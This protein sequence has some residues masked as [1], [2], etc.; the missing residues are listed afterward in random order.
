MR[1][2]SFSVLSSLLSPPSQHKLLSLRLRHSD[3]H[4]RDQQDW[5]EAQGTCRRRSRHPDCGSLRH[6][7]AARGSHGNSP[8]FRWQPLHSRLGPWSCVP[9]CVL[10]LDIS[11]QVNESSAPGALSNTRG[12]VA[13]AHWDVP[14]CGDSGERSFWPACP[15]S[16][17]RCHNP[18]SSSSACKQTA[19]W[20]RRT[21]GT[22]CLR[23]S[24]RAM[25]RAG[26]AYPLSVLLFADSRRAGEQHCRRH[27]G[28]GEALSQGGSPER[29]GDVVVSHSLFSIRPRIINSSNRAHP[30][31]AAPL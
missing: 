15:S 12:A 20:T 24:T 18:Q 22:A 10:V 26:G 4:A 21:A 8:S 7:A 17:T 31:V 14:D 23:R 16:E 1:E 9:S 27:C 6:P 30:A 19:I 25:R 28:R 5:S 29:E 2:A 11:S 3:G 13:V